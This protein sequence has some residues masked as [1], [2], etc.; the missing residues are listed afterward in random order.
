M[1]THVSSSCRN[2]R[3]HWQS[4]PEDRRKAWA[5][6]GMRLQD[7]PFTSSYPRSHSHPVPKERPVGWTCS[8]MSSKAFGARHPVTK[9][10]DPPATVATRLGVLRHLAG[11]IPRKNGKGEGR[12][13]TSYNCRPR[14]QP[15]ERMSHRRVLLGGPESAVCHASIRLPKRERSG[16]PSSGRGRWRGAHGI[17]SRRHA[18]VLGHLDREFLR[19]CRIRAPGHRGDNLCKAAAARACSFWW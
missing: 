14:D 15:R 18:F 12:D 11:A 5:G 10:A 6:T 2:P 16:Q 4:E 9:I 3:S 7:I 17:R 13:H 8:G 19:T 1:G